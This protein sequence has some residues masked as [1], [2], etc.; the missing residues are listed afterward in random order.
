[1]LESWGDA[2]GRTGFY[3]LLQP[4]IAPLFKTRYFQTALLKWSGN[5]A[6]YEDYFKEFW[7]KKLG[8]QGVFDKALQDGVV[9]PETLSF[10]SAQYNSAGEAGAAS[11]VGAGS[12]AGKA[13]LVLY[14]K[15]S[16]GSGA[17]ANNPWLQ[18]MPDPIT[19]AT[20]DN[21]AVISYAMAAELGLKLDDQYEVE[22]HKPVVAF[23]INGKELKLP[24]LATPGVHPNVIAVALG[25]GRREA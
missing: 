3:S 23:T 14:Q 5:D 22:F 20:W 10:A 21:Y 9:E 8:S 1:Y 2:E 13:E 25:S 24:I 6:D 11:K 16:M 19:R 18:E 12:P 4:T 15:V 17:A 7:I